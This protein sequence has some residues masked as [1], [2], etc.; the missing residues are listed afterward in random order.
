MFFVV[1]VVFYYSW[2]VQTLTGYR[3]VCLKSLIPT[4][5]HARIRKKTKK[6]TPVTL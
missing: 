6:D 1:G 5:A 3:S 2:T 4:T